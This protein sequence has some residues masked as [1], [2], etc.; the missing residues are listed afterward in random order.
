VSA[1]SDLWR[2][3][4]VLFFLYVCGGTAVSLFL[5]DRTV[6]LRGLWMMM[7]PF[8]TVYDVELDEGG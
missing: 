4:V 5:D 8:E 1:C 6:P 2:R 7:E 3:Q